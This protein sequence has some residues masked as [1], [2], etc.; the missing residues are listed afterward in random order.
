[1][2]FHFSQMKQLSFIKQDII[3]ALAKIRKTS[4]L[5]VLALWISSVEL[6]LNIREERVSKGLKEKGVDMNMM[7][8]KVYTVI[9]SR[10]I[11]QDNK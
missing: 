4:L 3:Q 7:L 11:R 1:M 10:K 2:L 6:Y 5:M 9:I 8:I